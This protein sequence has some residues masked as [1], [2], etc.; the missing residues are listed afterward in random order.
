MRKG[1]HHSE[2]ARRKTSKSCRGQVPWNKGLYGEDSPQWRGGRVKH[3]AGYIRIYAPHHP[4]KAKMGSGYVYEHRL[5]MEK[6]IERYLKP[7]ERV[8]HLNGI[9]DDNRIENLELLPN[10]GKHNTVVQ[11]VYKENKKLKEIIL[12]LL[13][14]NTHS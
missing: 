11:E 4:S 9:P 6:H 5:V 12:M 8:H 13:L 7:W 2:E 1:S 3:G 14:L 10:Q